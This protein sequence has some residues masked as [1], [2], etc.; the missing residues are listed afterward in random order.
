MSAPE[1]PAGP[2]VVV[3]ASAGGLE[4]CTKLID[5]LPAASG[6]AFILIQHLDPTHDS[7]LVDLLTSHTAMTVQQA[8]EGMAVE[9]EHLYVIP[10][11]AYLS[12]LTGFP[13]RILREL[14]TTDLD[15]TKWRLDGVE[16][17]LPVRKSIIR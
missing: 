8:T 11:G 6:M 5:A 12:T 4:A 10:P 3:G 7:M 15:C 14:S 16:R 13:S 1:A 9:P 17:G 2:V